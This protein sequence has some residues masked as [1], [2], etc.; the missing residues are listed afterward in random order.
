MRDSIWAHPASDEAMKKIERLERRVA[1]L[2]FALRI[3]RN[4]SPDPR[5][6]K[7]CTQYLAHREH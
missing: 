4:L 2:E 1:L 7:L 6:Q 5:I 3:I